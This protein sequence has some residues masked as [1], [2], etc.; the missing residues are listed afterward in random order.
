MPP[1]AQY[2]PAS[3]EKAFVE[4]VHSANC[5]GVVISWGAVGTPDGVNNHGEKYVNETFSALGYRLD[6][7]LTEALRGHL[8]R[9]TG[10]TR[11]ALRRANARSMVLAFR[12][13]V[14]VL[15]STDGNCTSNVQP[16]A[17]DEWDWESGPRTSHRSR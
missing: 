2:I 13:R 7:G 14:P 4:N 1:T 12:R 5:R 10:M 16:L 8:P 3:H 15:S 11:T 17:H 9:S 6:R